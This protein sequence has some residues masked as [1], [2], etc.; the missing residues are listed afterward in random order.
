VT[1]DTQWLFLATQLTKGASTPDPDE[2]LATR[3][4]PFSEAVLMVLRD[5]ICEAAST[6]SILKLDALRRHGLL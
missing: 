1:T 2:E 5:E 3:W 6:A 4:V